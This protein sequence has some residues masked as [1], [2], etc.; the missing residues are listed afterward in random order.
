[1]AGATASPTAPP[2][3]S[4]AYGPEGRSAWLDI[5]WSQ[6]LRWAYV[7]GSAVNYVDIGE[8]PTL[9]FIHGLSGCWQNWL[10]NIP[11]FART[12]RVIA[13]DLPGFGDSPMP[14]EKITISNYAGIVDELLDGLGI[15]RA[16]VVGNSMGGFIGA[17]LAIEYSTR[18]EKL[19]LVSAAG[20]TTMERHND[21][22]LAGLRRVDN[23]LAFGAAWAATRSDRLARRPRLRKALML[24]VAA[25]P[26]RLPAPL[27][28]EQI[29]GSGKPGFMDALEALGTYP[30][31]DRLERIEIPTL[32]VWGAKDWLVPV[33]DAKRFEQAIGANARRLVYDD[34]GHVAML[35]RPARFNADVE[36]FLADE[37]Q[38]GADSQ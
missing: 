12:H 33:R 36:A 21:R 29:A 32:I 9:V 20:L 19:V 38:P 17:E 14:R 23:V 34:T 6:H 7:R 25:H 2:A 13:L 35:E 4:D 1:M 5:D 28:A 16:V 18:V 31:E 10:E 26:D 15:E 8:G 37:T 3:T 24:M 30:L 22:L 11:Y 27:I